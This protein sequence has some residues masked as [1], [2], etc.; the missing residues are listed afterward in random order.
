MICLF[1]LSGSTNCALASLTDN[2]AHLLENNSYVRCLMVDF[3]TV[4]DTVHHVIL[5]HKPLALNLP[6]NVCMD[7][8]FLKN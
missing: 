2:V 4:F 5:I 8:F 1:S 6:P 3:S 7:Y